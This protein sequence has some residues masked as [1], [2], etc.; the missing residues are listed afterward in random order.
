MRK[1]SLCK[2]R[3]LLQDCI[4]LINEIMRYEVKMKVW[5]TRLNKPHLQGFENLEGV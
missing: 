1:G 3:V 2:K 4:I 5:F